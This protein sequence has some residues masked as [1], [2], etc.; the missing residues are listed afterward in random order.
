MSIN[1]KDYYDNTFSCNRQA[2]AESV[3]IKH[4]LHLFCAKKFCPQNSKHGF[5]FEKKKKNLRGRSKLAEEEMHVKSACPSLKKFH[6][7]S[8]MLHCKFEES[9]SGHQNLSETF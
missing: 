7:N 5:H 4:Q 6:N 3:C 9:S 8:S 2:L 1:P